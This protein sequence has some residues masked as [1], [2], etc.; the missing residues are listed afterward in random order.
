MLVLSSFM[1]SA[2]LYHWF[3]K[4]KVLLLDAPGD[5][6]KFQSM[7]STHLV[8]TVFPTAAYLIIVRSASCSSTQYLTLM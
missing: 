7:L 4:I 3:M 2:D 8:V 6:G 1:Y 5:E